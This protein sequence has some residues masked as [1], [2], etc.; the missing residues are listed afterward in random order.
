MHCASTDI[1]GRWGGEEF[2][3]ILPLSAPDKLGIL[4]EKL[5]MLVEKSELRLASGALHVTISLGCTCI[6]EGDDTLSLVRRAG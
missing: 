5:R 3:C 1:L 6:R 4:S 2:L